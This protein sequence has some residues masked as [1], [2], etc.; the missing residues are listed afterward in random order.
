MNLNFRK[1][2]FHGL[3]IAL[4]YLS[5]SF[6]F[7]IMAVKSGLSVFASAMISVTNLTSAGQVAGVG[8]IVAGGTLFEMA[9]TQLIINLRYSLM[10]LSLSQKLSPEFTLRH[11]LMASYGITDEIFAVA[12]SQPCLLT[13]SYMYGMILVAFLGWVSGTVLGA[14]AGEILPKEVTDAMGIVLYGMFL[15][16][17]IPPSRKQKSVLFTVVL[18]A[19]ISILFRYVFTDISSGFAIIISALVSASVGALLF[20]V[21]DDEEEVQKQ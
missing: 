2:M 9:L 17:I 21:K 14:S 16:I 11:R 5:V 18:S 10:S 15:A 13:P 12:S 3:P 20:P 4:G 8:I 6:G 7:G 1:G 19:L